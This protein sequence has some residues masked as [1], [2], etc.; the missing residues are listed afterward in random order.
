MYEEPKLSEAEWE[1]VTELLECERS[2]LPVE[3]HHTHNSS[4]RVELQQ[5]MEMVRQLLDRLQMPTAV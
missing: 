1:L 2:E 4:V 5:R 3:I